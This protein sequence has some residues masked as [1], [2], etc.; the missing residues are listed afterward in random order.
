MNSGDSNVKWTMLDQRV[1]FRNSFVG[2]RNDSVR[3]PDGEIID[4]IV[5]E[6]RNYSAVV[7]FDDYGS[8][9]LVKQYRY[10]WEQLSW[11]IPSGLV[12]SGET[13]KECAT[14]EVQEETGYFVNS[15]KPLIRYHPT[16][17]GPGWCH[18][19][20]AEVEKGHK[21]PLEPHEI[22]K[23]DAFKPELVDRMILTGEI[24][25]AATILGWSRRVSYDTH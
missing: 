7:C 19:F 23:V 12:E 17:L 25:H 6:N 13:P 4:F 8:V 3:R 14:R 10:P 22:V 1:V 9:I 15:I 24:V 21:Q 18:I 2:L 5:V 16:G 20:L 11:E